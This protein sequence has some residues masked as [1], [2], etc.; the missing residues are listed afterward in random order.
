MNDGRVLFY[1]IRDVLTACSSKQALKDPTTPF[2]AV[3]DPENWRKLMDRFDMGI[4]MEM[5]PSDILETKA[6]VNYDSL[7]GTFHIPRRSDLQGRPHRFAFA[8]D[9]RG[10]VFIENGEYVKKV[11]GSIQQSMKWKMP[12]IE[13]FLYDFLE[14]I[15]GGDLAVLRSMERELNAL[16]DS[17]LNGEQ[18]EFPGRLKEI[19]SILMS[20]RVHYEQ[21]IDLGQELEENENGFFASENLRFFRL[22]TDRVTRLQDKSASLRDYTVQLRE[23]FSAQLDIRQNRIMTVLTVITAI[24]MPLTLIVGWYGMN[25]TNMPELTAPFGYPAVIII[26]IVIV[27]VSVIWFNGRS[28]YETGQKQLSR[29]RKSRGGQII[30]CARIFT[31]ESFR[32]QRRKFGAVNV[33]KCKYFVRLL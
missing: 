10:I 16:E 6:V 19:R 30:V 14:K 26:S 13:R 15:I 33:S 5:N 1:Q 24:F 12:S 27:V 21:M 11:L 17:I 8:M 2:V 25:F 28:G 23:L 32:L 22:F 31:A 20:L 4:D 9:E 7:T 18:E 29:I 3:L